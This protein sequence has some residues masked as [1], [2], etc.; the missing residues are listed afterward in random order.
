MCVGGT[1][2]TREAWRVGFDAVLPIESMRKMREAAGICPI[3][4]LIYLFGGVCGRKR[5]TSCEQYSLKT[6]K[7][8]SAGKMKV[9]KACFT[10]CLDGSLVYLLD[11]CS[12]STTL[13]VFCPATGQFSTTPIAISGLFN[14]SLCGI[15]DDFL[16]I[17][18]A[19][20]DFTSISLPLRSQIIPFPTN[21]STLGPH[22]LCLT[23]PL[24]LNSTLYW[25]EVATGAFWQADSSGNAREWVN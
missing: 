3:G 14:H 2:A 24:V 13:E 9:G 10:P 19:D 1:P 25:A 6:G 11:L 17:F 4:A 7:W 16:L 18:T 21:C 15:I 5:L 12:N 8:G 23:P 20:G 22:I